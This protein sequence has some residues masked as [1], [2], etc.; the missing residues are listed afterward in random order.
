[1]STIFFVFF[2]SNILF[3][4]LINFIQETQKHLISFTFVYIRDLCIP[5]YKETQ[6]KY[7]YLWLIKAQ[8][9]ICKSILLVVFFFIQSNYATLV[10]NLNRIAIQHD[11]EFKKQK[12]KV[13][14]EKKLKWSWTSLGKCFWIYV[15][16]F[17]LNFE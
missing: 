17:G 16:R 7:L 1:M 12:K 6:Q 8:S 11:I 4:C 10:W 2:L 15:S 5:S 9:G 14:F 13:S 3:F